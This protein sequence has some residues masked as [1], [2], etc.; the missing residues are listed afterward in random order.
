MKKGILCS[1]LLLGIFTVQAQTT[2][3]ETLKYNDVEKISINLEEIAYREMGSGD[4]TLLFIHGL[5]SNLEAWNKNIAAL[6]DKYKCIAIDLPGYGKSSKNKLDHSITDYADVIHQFIQKKDLKQTILIGHSMGG[7]IAIRSVLDYPADFLKLILIAPAGIETFSAGE[8]QIMKASYTPV[9]LRE[10]T[11]EQIRANFL[12]N[13]HEFPEDAEFMVEDR[14]AM[15][16]A[17][18]F[19]NYSQIVV[20]NIHAMLDEP[21]I[22]ELSKIKIPVLMIFGSNDALIP[23]KYFHRDQ[24]LEMLSNIAKEKLPQLEVKIIEDAGHFVNFEKAEIVNKEM[25]YFLKE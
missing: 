21:V 5:S 18:D 11:E 2:I 22:E 13:F 16:K 8:A 20:N 24:D 23:N 6:K 14:I 15:K 10:A 4:T 3:S 9:M 19:E 12:I 1:I 25:S 17:S 7:Q